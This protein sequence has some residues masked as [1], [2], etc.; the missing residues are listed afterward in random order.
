MQTLVGSSAGLNVNPSEAVSSRVD[1]SCRPHGRSIEEDWNRD[2][3]VCRSVILPGQ[4]THVQPSCAWRSLAG[5]VL[6]PGAVLALYRRVFI[7]Y[8]LKSDISTS[9][10][11]MMFSPVCIEVIRHRKFLFVTTIIACG[12]IRSR[13]PAN[14]ISPRFCG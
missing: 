5:A 8:V 7:W 14:P 12:D 4:A 1:T 3:A 9:I 2:E 11:I 10:L 6:D 13:R